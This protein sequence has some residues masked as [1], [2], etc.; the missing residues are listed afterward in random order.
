MTIPS[1]A[2]HLEMATEFAGFLM[3]PEGQSILYDNYQPSIV[4]AETDDLDG[5]P[6]ALKPLVNEEENPQG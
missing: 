6:D 2:P 5:L 4:P 1:N 3:G